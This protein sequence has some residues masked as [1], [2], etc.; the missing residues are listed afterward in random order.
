MQERKSIKLSVTEWQKLDNLATVT[1]SLAHAGIKG[2]ERRYSWRTLLKRIAKGELII[3][4][5]F[6]VNATK[7]V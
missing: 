4:E 6:K 7:V 2:N 3:S 1:N 5:N